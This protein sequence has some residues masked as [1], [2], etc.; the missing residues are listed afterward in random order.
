MKPIEAFLQR[1]VPWYCTRHAEKPLLISADFSAMLVAFCLAQLYLFL[2]NYDSNTDALR[3]WWAES[4]FMRL[5]VYLPLTFIAVVWLGLE[6]AYSKRRPYYDQIREVLKVSFIIGLL[7]ASLMYFQK[8]P[9]SRAALLINWFLVPCLIVAIRIVVKNALVR[10][11]GWTRPMIIIGWGN[12]AIE[13]ARAFDDERSM[14]FRLAAFLIPHEKDRPGIQYKDHLGNHVPCIQLAQN[15]ATMLDSMSNVHVVI[16]LEP[17]GIELMQPMLQQMTRRHID[18]QIVPS[19]RGFPLYGMQV[20]HFFRHEVFLLTIRNN[21]AQRGKQVLKRAFD[22]FASSFMLIVGLPLLVW[23][24]LGVAMSGRPIFFGHR[25]IGKRRKPFV[26]YKFRTML[27]NSE[28][29]LSDLLRRDPEAKADWE[30]DFKLR[31]DPRITRFGQFLRKTS[32]DELP[33]LWN[34]LK[35]DMSLVGPR[36]IVEAELERYGNQVGYYLESRP[37]ITGL[38]QISGRNDVTY[39][40]R[41]RLDSWYVKNWSLFTDI[42]IL[43]ETIKVVL[44]KEGAY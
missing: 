9:F 43:V 44:K 31:N 20:N 4:G 14:G 11:G 1:D 19:L 6:G 24:A 10:M 42:G 32:L 12:N 16:A 34:V 22:I 2:P 21:L 40:T 27:P 5:G 28:Q 36:P 15:P 35:G 33:Q 30:R 8:S 26:C 29:I 7:D 17:D 41:V 18:V 38:W 13:I 3:T 25:R 23:I 37:G 39:E